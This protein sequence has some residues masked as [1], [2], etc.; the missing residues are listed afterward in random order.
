MRKKK[1]DVN[2]F[3]EKRE[4]KQSWGKVLL[5][6]FFVCFGLF[7]GAYCL[8]MYMGAHN[9]T[10]VKFKINPEFGFIVNGNDEVVHYLALN[11][12]ARKI[13]NL[14]MFK[15]KKTNEAVSKAVEVA[16]QN[17]YLVD[18]NKKIEVTVVSKEETEKTVVEDKILNVI[19][20]KDSTVVAEVVEPTEEDKE[21]FT[22]I[23]LDKIEEVEETVKKKEEE[24]KICNYTKVS[25]EDMSGD[26]RTLTA[27][28]T[29]IRMYPKGSKN[30]VLVNSSD[31]IQGSISNSLASVLDAPI[32]FIDVNSIK[33]EVLNEL[34]RLNVENVYILGGVGSISD[35][36]IKIIKD[37][38]GIDAQRVFGADRYITSIE[39]AKK[40]D[41]HKTI[42]SVI[43]AAGENE[44]VDAAMISAISGAKNMP[45]LYTKKDSLVP[46]VKDYIKSNKNIN[47]IYV[48]GGLIT[49]NVISELESLGRGVEVIFGKDRYITNANVLNKFQTKFR[50]VVLVNNIVDVVIAARFAS[51]NDSAL[52]Y[53]KDNLS[54]EH[55]K[56]V[57]SNSSINK[58]YYFGGESMKV[59][60]RNSL[61]NIKKSNMSKCEN[62]TEELLFQNKK[63]VFY[64]PHQ[65]DES[66]YY[67]QTITSAIEK[68]GADNVYLVLMTYGN[69]SAAQNTEFVKNA[70]S[71]YN[72]KNNSNLNFSTARDKEFLASVKEL[73]VKNVK[74][75]DELNLVDNPC[76]VSE[77]ALE[78]GGCRFKDTAFASAGPRKNNTYLED[79]KYLVEFIKKYD[80][81]LGG[82][83]THFAY[84]FLDEHFDHA[85]MGNALTQLYFDTSIKDESFE[86]VYLIV[87]SDQMYG[88]SK[89][90]MPKGSAINP[91][92]ETNIPADKYVVLKNKSGFDNILNS[93]S[94]YGYD[95][96]KKECVTTD[97]I[98]GV[99]C[100]SVKNT[101]MSLTDRLQR[102]SNNP[103]QTTI[104]IPFKK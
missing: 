91:G 33:E 27:I 26:N 13:F 28:N 20:E 79:Y 3:W 75:I 42:T 77:L 104:H 98:I 6:I 84:S 60:F 56:L 9:L 29:S 83:V 51:D 74:F 37:N 4:L 50:S 39:I 86:N 76:R 41:E 10:F 103:L 72:K 58:L 1:V 49:K 47:T 18:E 46:S 96:N 69:A 102:N 57:K 14:N 7:Y 2:E 15:G 23:K 82:D 32:L 90:I 54:D 52:M 95:I 19:K 21:I 99:G 11:D 100:V 25:Y 12:D 30:V 89:H 22:D 38:Y 65:D 68:L 87:K 70:I 31:M 24:K 71:D 8:D 78:G 35:N 43:V 88:D 101:F 59:G 17:N 44:P 62:I 67:G 55:I 64:V 85:A 16:K 81:K 5:S 45:I 80:K 66:L 92:K 34:T 94:K 97:E 63:A 40:V 61:F 53:I 93:F 73:G 36:V 48:S